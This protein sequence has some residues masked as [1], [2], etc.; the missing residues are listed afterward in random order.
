MDSSDGARKKVQT[1][2]HKK[3]KKQSVPIDSV[4]YQTLLDQIEKTL[5]EAERNQSNTISAVNEAMEEISS[6]KAK[7]SALQ[8][9]QGSMAGNLDSTTSRVATCKVTLHQ[10]GQQLQEVIHRQGTVTA[11]WDAFQQKWKTGTAG[12]GGPQQEASHATNFFLGGIPQLQ[13]PWVSQPTVTRWK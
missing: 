10:H 7:V 8:A 5:I 12:T 9:A 6:L 13:Y 4:M 3:K 11:Q 1:T 2:I